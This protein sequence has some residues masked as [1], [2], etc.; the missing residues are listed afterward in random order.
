M[1]DLAA[2]PRGTLPQLKVR[3]P[4]ESW[5]V[6]TLPAFEDDPTMVYAVFPRDPHYHLA[7]AT[8]HATLCGLPLRGRV[9]HVAVRQPPARVTVEP[10]PNSC[11][12]CPTCQ[13]AQGLRACGEVTKQVQG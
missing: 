13:A 10:P 2:S 5:R 12:V 3:T 6:N 8:K 7:W 1:L 11:P 4:D 9:Q